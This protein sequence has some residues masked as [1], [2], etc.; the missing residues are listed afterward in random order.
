MPPKKNKSGGGS[1][2]RKSPAKGGG[3]AG[4]AAAPGP[5]NGPS[6]IARGASPAPAGRVRRIVGPLTG[7]APDSAAAAAAATGPMDVDPPPGSGN[8]AAAAAAAAPARAGAP[9][10]MMDALAAARL[11]Q[12]QSSRQPPRG[13]AAAGD[14]SSGDD[15]TSGPAGAAGGGSSSS[16]DD[17]GRPAKRQRPESGRDALT[18][19]PANVDVRTMSWNTQKRADIAREPFFTLLGSLDANVVCVQ[20]PPR[21]LMHPGQSTFTANGREPRDAESLSFTCVVVPDTDCALLYRNV[22]GLSVKCKA[23]R[24]PKLGQYGGQDHDRAVLEATVTQDG[25][26]LRIW[27]VHAPYKEATAANAF[28]QHVFARAAAL[29]ARGEGPDVIMGDVN[30]HGGGRDAGRAGGYQ[31]ILQSPTSNFGQGD[32]LDQIYVRPGWA[33]DPR[34]GPVCG[35]LVHGSVAGLSRVDKA[36][37]LV[38]DVEGGRLVRMSDHLPIYANFPVEVRPAAGAPAAAAAASSSSSSPPS[39][40]PPSSSHAAMAIRDN[41]DRIARLEQQ[42]EDTKD[43]DALASIDDTIRSLRSQIRAL[44]GLD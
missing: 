20:E 43:D 32:P 36:S 42:R 23:I 39:R 16:R 34:G 6:S 2:K 13:S 19:A 11:R 8:G 14:D 1:N 31:C 28:M 10:S 33:I 25:A 3:S 22:P 38:A 5:S 9:G 7:A 27:T 12:Y 37:G 35:R 30:L 40:P 15:E 26:T 41:E 24:I 44:R 17:S 18:S 4:S 21:F 29:A